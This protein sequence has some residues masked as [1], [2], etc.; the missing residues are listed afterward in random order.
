MHFSTPA[1]IRF[2]RRLALTGWTAAALAF[3]APAG[4]AL[5]QNVVATV[6][7]KAITSFD[8]QQRIKLGS[9]TQKRA[10]NGKIALQELIDDQV[11]ILEARRIGYRVTED[12]V[13]FE[14][15]RLAKG[16]NQSASQFADTLRRA[17][18]EP[19]LLR[20]SMRANLAWE[21]LLRDRARMG[22]H[23]TREEIDAEISK[24]KAGEGTITEYELVQVLFIV[25]QGSGK[26]GAQQ[27]AAASARAGFSSCE[28]G[29]EKFRTM[30]DVAVKDRVTRTS[31]DLN[32][33]LRKLLDQ[34]PAGKMTPPSATQQGYEVIA[35]CAKKQRD[36][37]ELERSAIANELTQKK[38]QEG[39]KGYLESLRKKYNI[40]Y[41]R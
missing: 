29:I 40:V 11:K 34:T 22:S 19:E 38:F 35:V 5:A 10:V 18:L 33:A 32:P 14:F 31:S 36:N 2:L 13:D 12:G 15:T 25:P 7:G 3:S 37:P 20:E 9:M 26:A 4:I 30:T 1:C 17:G 21:A 41:R 8:V 39:A 6:N 16:Y 23:V 24:K 27:R 28:D